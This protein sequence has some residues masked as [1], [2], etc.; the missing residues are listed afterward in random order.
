MYFLQYISMLTS[1]VKSRAP[2]AQH[3]QGKHGLETRI[4]AQVGSACRCGC[5]RCGRV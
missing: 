3:Q 1:V 5:R 4:K 2:T